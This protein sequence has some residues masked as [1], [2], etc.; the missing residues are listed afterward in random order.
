MKNLLLSAVVMLCLAACASIG[1]KLSD[2]ERLE[3]YR[4]HAGEPVRSFTDLG[5]LHSWTALGESA[6]AVWVT[7]NQAYLLE[8]DRRCENLNF[9]QTVGF[10]GTAGTVLAGLDNVVVRGSDRPNF[11]CGINQIRPLDVKALKTAEQ[12]AR[13]SARKSG[14]GR[15]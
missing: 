8:L 15:P 7:P 6:L 10:T 12:N 2:N 5:N 13:D 11:P 1:A 3:I 4:S 14:A 9:A